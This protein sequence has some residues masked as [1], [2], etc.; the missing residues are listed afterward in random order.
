MKSQKTYLMAD[1]VQQRKALVEQGVHSVG[2]RRELFYQDL[3]EQ[4]SL[5]LHSVLTIRMF[6][7]AGIEKTVSK[8]FSL[9]A[10]KK[11]RK[12]RVLFSG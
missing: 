11:K 6:F 5:G 9:L 7:P 2:R 10:F 3:C 8:A 4:I 1:E 12:V